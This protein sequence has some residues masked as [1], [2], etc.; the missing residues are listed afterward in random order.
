MESPDWQPLLLIT[1]S[2]N[3]NKIIY[4]N[5][6]RSYPELLCFITK[7][8]QTLVM[9]WLAGKYEIKK[10]RKPHTHTSNASFFQIN[11]IVCATFLMFFLFSVTI[12]YLEYHLSATPGYFCSA[13]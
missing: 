6:C 3:T 8:K 5:F 13:L 9:C 10:K 1:V 11:S 7:R 2:L 12:C 4:L